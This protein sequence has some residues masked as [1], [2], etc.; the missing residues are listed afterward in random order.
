VWATHGNR[1][2][3]L[4]APPR[5]KRPRRRL[6]ARQRQGLHA[7]ADLARAGISGATPVFTTGVMPVST[8]L[9]SRSVLFIGIVLAIE[10]HDDV[11]LDKAKCYIDTP[12]LDLIGRMHGRGW[13]TRMT[14]W[15]QIARD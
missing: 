5:P 6:E 10:V 2:H 1:A 7:R 15:F 14:D 13:Y 3:L 4:F 12:K 8:T 9:P 11:V